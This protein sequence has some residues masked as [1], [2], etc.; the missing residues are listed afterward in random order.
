MST[1]TYLEASKS[2]QL[3]M[4]T[5]L[6]NRKHFCCRMMQLLSQLDHHHALYRCIPNSSPT[7]G[8]LRSQ[9]M[10]HFVLIFL[11]PS[12]STTPFPNLCQSLWMVVFSMRLALVLGEV[13]K[14]IPNSKQF[15]GM[16]VIRLQQLEILLG[17][18][19][20]WDT[21]GRS[22]CLDMCNFLDFHYVHLIVHD[23]LSL[24]L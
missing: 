1:R 5:I 8:Y 13:L 9:L 20:P 23:V 11:H 14:I 15:S 22:D 17:R 24:I 2:P 19:T 16:D 7:T 12:S 3:D 6:A 10:V 21:C 18:S 4:F